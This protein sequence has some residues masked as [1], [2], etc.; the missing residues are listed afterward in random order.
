MT[1]G[2]IIHQRPLSRSSDD[3][4]VAAYILLST[5][6]KLPASSICFH[7][8]LQNFY[9]IIASPAAQLNLNITF[10]KIGSLDSIVEVPSKNQPP[11]AT[12]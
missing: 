7:H 6:Q 3:K 12:C 10:D 4:E 1:R 2:V 8:T 5:A 9:C 11:T